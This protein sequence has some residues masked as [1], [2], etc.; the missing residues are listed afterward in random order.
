MFNTRIWREA[1]AASLTYGRK[2]GLLPLF[3]D[4]DDEGVAFYLARVRDGADAATGSPMSRSQR[5]DKTKRDLFTTN[6]PVR[7]PLAHATYAGVARP[8]FP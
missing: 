1:S 2:R 8:H 4:R 6:N 7:L 5:L 3:E